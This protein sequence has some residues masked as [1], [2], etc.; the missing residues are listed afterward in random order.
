MSLSGK[1]REEDPSFAPSPLEYF[2]LGY[3]FLDCPD[4]TST[5]R[6]GHVL[7]ET[8]RKNRGHSFVYTLPES[9][10]LQIKPKKKSAG[11]GR[12]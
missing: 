5:T 8:T 6:R 1:E 7:E 9:I 11:G 12:G 4:D 10:T 3:C 2:A